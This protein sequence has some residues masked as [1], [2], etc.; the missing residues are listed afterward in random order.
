MAKTRVRS[1]SVPPL[2]HS[3]KLFKLMG[4]TGLVVSTG[5]FA[6]QTYSLKQAVEVQEKILHLTGSYP[7]FNPELEFIEIPDHKTGMLPMDSL[8]A[9]NEIKSMIP[10]HLRKSWK[11]LHQA[12]IV[13]TL[14]IFRFLRQLILRCCNFVLTSALE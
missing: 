6:Y 11:L 8:E 4:T 10:K 9:K 13:R 7:I 3:R 14:M 5:Y 12:N 1:I 2:M